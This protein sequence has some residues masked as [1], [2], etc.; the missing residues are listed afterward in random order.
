M[1][2]RETLETWFPSRDSVAL[3]VQCYYC[4]YV[5]HIVYSMI[6]PS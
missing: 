3:D 6:V 4:V 5:V 1:D 2:G